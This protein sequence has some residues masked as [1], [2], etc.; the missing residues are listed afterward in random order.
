MRFRTTNTEVGKRDDS[1]LCCFTP[2]LGDAAE[3]HDDLGWEE[4]E[5]NRKN[6]IGEGINEYFHVHF[7]Q[8]FLTRSFMKW[9]MIP[10]TVNAAIFDE[11]ASALLQFDVVNF[12]HHAAG[13]THFFRL[14]VF[15][16]G[17]IDSVDISNAKLLSGLLLPFG[18]CWPPTVKKWSVV[19]QEEQKAEASFHRRCTIL[20]PT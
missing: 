14:C 17:D 9:P 13:G 4:S 8:S 2:F 20:I 11:F 5:N 19:N 18:C 15:D 7:G 12:C 16:H 6:L 3:A 1:L 10:L